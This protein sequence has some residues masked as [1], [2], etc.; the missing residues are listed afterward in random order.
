MKLVEVFIAL[1]VV[2]CHASFVLPSCALNGIVFSST[3]TDVTAK[4][5][6]YIIIFTAETTS[7]CIV[8]KDD[9]VKYYFAF[10]FQRVR[11]PS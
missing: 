1:L 9:L 7:N 5:G 10:I 4:A 8:H 2:F 3:K 6:I 11:C